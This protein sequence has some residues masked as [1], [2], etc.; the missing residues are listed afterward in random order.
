[1][2]GDNGRDEARGGVSAPPVIGPPSDPER[3]YAE[4][5]LNV[6]FENMVAAVLI[7]AAVSGAVLFV[8]NNLMLLAK[9]AWSFGALVS[10]AMGAFYFLFLAF[11][12]GFL[13]AVVVATP[14]FVALERAKLRK[15]WPYVLAAIAVQYVALGVMTGGIPT[16]ERPAS[17]VFFAPGVLTAV[18]F[19]RRMRGAW[20][21]AE[22][23]ESQPVIY[24]VH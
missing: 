15:T 14:L 3:V 2:L 6:A 17:L 4:V 12:I 19:G 11:L 21:A 5:R 9:G 13:A 18:L 23:A 10:A 7:G 16:F 24:R 8:G 22:R 1:M 20:R